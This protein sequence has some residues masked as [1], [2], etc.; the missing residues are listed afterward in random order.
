MNKK[1]VLLKEIDIVQWIINRMWT[2]SFVIKGWAISIV[3]W[4]LSLNDFSKS[5]WLFLI[6]IM[7]IA[8]LL[9][10]YLD[11]YFLQQERLYRKLYKWIVDNREKSD[12][13]LFDTNT[14][15]LFRKEDCILRVFFSKTIR[16]IYFLLIISTIIYYVLIF[17]IR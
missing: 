14:D 6:I 17:N 15:R 4:V 13:F 3:L 5:D 11:S 16:P 9:F 7:I 2:N 12:E 1:D 10:A 8:I